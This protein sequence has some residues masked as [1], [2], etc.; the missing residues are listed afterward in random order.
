VAFPDSLHGWAGG[1][2]GLIV[3]TTDGGETWESYHVDSSSFGITSLSFVDSANG[4]AADPFDG[5]YRYD[6]PQSAEPLT[7]YLAQ[8]EFRI[9]P[10]YP[11]PFNVATTITYSISAP[12]T[13]EARVYDLSAR[14]IALLFNGPVMAGEHELHWNGSNIASGIYFCQISSGGRETAWAKLLLI[15]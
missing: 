13:I 15:K 2:N 1:H 10:A 9:N 7:N 8:P 12:T 5:V 6:S 4:W 11:N 14:V 3:Q